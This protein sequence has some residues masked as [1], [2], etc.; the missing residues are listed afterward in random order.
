MSLRRKPEADVLAEIRDWF[1]RGYVEAASE[2]LESFAAKAK[3]EEIL[4]EALRLAC[5]VLRSPLPKRKGGRPPNP[6]RPTTSGSVV[7][8]GAMAPMSDAQ[9][10]RMV[11]GMVSDYAI[12]EAVDAL[13][14][15]FDVSG[16]IWEVARELNPKKPN[17]PEVRKAY[18]R[19]KTAK[20]S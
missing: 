5:E 14:G 12:A 18:Y 2:R 13:L 11:K 3:D 20:Q 19:V 1:G 9:K 7:D 17:E 4:R 8:I 15:K 16:A 10:R 6:L